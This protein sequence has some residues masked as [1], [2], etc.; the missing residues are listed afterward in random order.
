MLVLL[1]WSGSLSF[2]C[3]GGGVAGREREEVW[4]DFFF[5]SILDGMLVETVGTEE[6][7]AV[8]LTDVE[9]GDFGTVRENIWE[10]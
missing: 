10:G 6:E 7:A 3:F 5:S 4:L 1:S 8:V 2:F 9:D